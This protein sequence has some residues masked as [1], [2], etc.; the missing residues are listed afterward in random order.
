M[1]RLIV[2]ASIVAALG[3]GTAGR[4][5]AQI[6]Y[7]Y[8]TRQDDGLRYTPS[9]PRVT[10]A[11]NWSYPMSSSSNYSSSGSGGYS[12]ISIYPPIYPPMG[13]NYRLSPVRMY[14]GAVYGMGYGMSPG[15]ARMNGM[16]ALYGGIG[17][18]WMRR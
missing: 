13:P 3:F 6:V 5:H 7:G 15:Y 8:S 12:P 9:M 17:P 14:G 18:M 2:A 10:Y 16:N 4:A 11:P 1:R